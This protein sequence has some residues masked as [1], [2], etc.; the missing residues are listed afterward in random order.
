MSIGRTEQAPRPPSA[1][2]GGRGRGHSGLSATALAL[3]KEWRHL[4]LPGAGARVVV[5]AS[6]GADSTALLLALDE[7]LK[8]RRLDLRLVAAHLDH[9]LREESV[10]DAR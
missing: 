6:G 3:L 8:A 9:G 7:L 5:A 2:R 10:E 4:S 1:R